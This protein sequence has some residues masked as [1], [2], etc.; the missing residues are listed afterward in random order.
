[1]HAYFQ[2]TLGIGCRL[3]G[4]CN[5]ADEY[6]QFLYE[7]QNGII[8]PPKDRWNVDAYYS[9]GSKYVMEHH[10]YLVLFSLL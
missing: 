5:S 9:E 8:P 4:G 6:Y 1:M 3:P 2:I 10:N 7:K